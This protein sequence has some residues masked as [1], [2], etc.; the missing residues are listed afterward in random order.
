MV[1]YREQYIASQGPRKKRTHPARS[2]QAL[3]TSGAGIVHRNMMD[4]Q[5][6]PNL[7]G[8]DVDRLKGLALLFFEHHVPIQI[9]VFQALHTWQNNYFKDYQND[10][11]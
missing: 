4:L 10:D 11:H 2:A 5:R 9:V 6:Q 8:A 3:N 7:S 1:D